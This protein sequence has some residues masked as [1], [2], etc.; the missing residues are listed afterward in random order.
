MRFLPLAVFAVAAIAIGAT[1]WF[2]SGGPEA[3]LD[4][5][6]TPERI[7][8]GKAVYTDHCAA[9]HGV[10][11]EGQP[12]WRARNPDGRLPAPPHDPSGHTWHHPDQML[13][14]VTKYGPQV[15]AGQDYQSDM[16]GFEGVLTDQEIIDVLVYIKSTWPLEIQQEQARRTKLSQQN[17]S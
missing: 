15:T 7:A 5:A 4:G 17:A 9:C 12:N 10:E 2:R 3:A 8:L 14:A 1:V 11:L 13:F 6:A 16:P